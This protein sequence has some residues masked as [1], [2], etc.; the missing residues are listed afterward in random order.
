MHGGANICML[1]ALPT[2]F[3]PSFARG[4]ECTSDKA[5]INKR[6]ALAAGLLACVAPRVW[7]GAAPSRGRLRSVGYLSPVASGD[8]FRQF[9][10]RVRSLGYIEGRS[11]AIHFRDAQTEQAAGIAA[12]DLVRRSVD[13][14]IAQAPVALRAARE[15]TSSIPIVTF[16][17]G[18]PVR[19]GVTTSLARP[20][21]NVTGF[22]WDAGIDTVVKGLE[23]AK[24]LL[25]RAQR[26][27]LLWNLENDSHPFYVKEF[28]ALS[29]RF[30]LSIQSVGVRRED[31]FDAALGAMVA[32]QAAMVI[33]FTDPFTIAHRGTLSDSLARHPLPAMWGSAAWPL[34]G[35]LATYGADVS[36]HPRRAAEYMHRLL[37]G[38]V[39][40][41][42]PFQQPTR[43]NLALDLRVA[44]S[45]GISVPK[46]LLLRADSVV[47]D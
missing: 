29:G 4:A 15:A 45:M 18:D 5:M 17:I 10:K 2:N 33:V 28:Q 34:Q 24:E 12:A 43:F 30:G 14:L 38:A 31:E 6:A 41:D 42:L 23:L 32:Q 19:M 27:A 1:A 7:C 40:G 21:A 35:A 16:F 44:R 22:T 39:A 3:P 20:S 37:E 25:P 11:L 8:A 46:R 26:I 13:V 47:G 9:L 36:D